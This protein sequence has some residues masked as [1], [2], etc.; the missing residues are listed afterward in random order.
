MSQDERPQRLRATY[1]KADTLRYIAHHYAGTRKEFISDA[2][3]L[4][5]K[6]TTASAN[7][8]CMKRGEW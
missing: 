3:E 1:R 7:W 4:G 8:A 2:M 5:I 6:E